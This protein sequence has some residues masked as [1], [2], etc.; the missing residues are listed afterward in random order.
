MELWEQL[1][2]HPELSK[3]YWLFIGFLVLMDVP[4]DK[5]E[6]FIEWVAA[7]PNRMDIYVSGAAGRKSLVEEFLAL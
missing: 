4:R 7:D 3:I 5:M 6:A 1:K 2:G